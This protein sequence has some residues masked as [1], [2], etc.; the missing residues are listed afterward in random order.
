MGSSGG[1]EI[2]SFILERGLGLLLIFF[3]G[4]QL[5]QGLKHGSLT[6]MR[7]IRRSE[8][9]F[10]YWIYMFAFFSFLVGGVKLL[11]VGSFF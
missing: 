6:F 4:Y 8:D 1:S 2:Y 11:I 10:A 5:A 7:V 9:P 3:C